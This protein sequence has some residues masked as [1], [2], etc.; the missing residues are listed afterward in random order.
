MTKNHTDISCHCLLDGKKSDKCRLQHIECPAGARPLSKSCGCG[1][2]RI[3][4]IDGSRRECAK[5]AQLGVLP[6]SELELLCP[7]R[8]R[9][10]MVKIN[11]GTLS[12]DELTAK[13]I[14][15]T[16]L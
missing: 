13:N 14:L 8:G 12:L 16:P 15:V 10:C 7:G 4:K 11:G 3:C 2:V 9:Q 6:G 5:M 1:R